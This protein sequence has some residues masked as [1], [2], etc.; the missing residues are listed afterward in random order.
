MREPDLAKQISNDFLSDKDITRIIAEEEVRRSIQEQLQLQNQI[1]SPWNA[2]L[3][4]F[5]NTPFG[6]W[7]LSSILVG[8]IGWGYATW[9]DHLQ[10][11]TANSQAVSRLDTEISTR[12]STFSGV[13]NS[14]VGFA[15]YDCAFQILLKPLNPQCLPGGFT[16]YRNRGLLSLLQELKLR[17]PESEKTA[18]QDTIDSAQQLE[19]VFIDN[20]ER[21]LK[22]DKDEDSLDFDQ[23][24]LVYKLF[25][26][27]NSTRW[28]IEHLR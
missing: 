7:L 16:E 4:R 21:R 3:L 2:R 20:T 27:I 23:L 5:L 13:I 6:I 28:P 15:A 11:Q 14:S 8:A 12:L 22:G 18:V 17:V 19:G 25:N 26:G 1:N 10:E 9:Q 24:E